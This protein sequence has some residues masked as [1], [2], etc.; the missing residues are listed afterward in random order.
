MKKKKGEK[1]ERDHFLS[2]AV[3]VVE[4]VAV[5]TAVAVAVSVS[6]VLAVASSALGSASLEEAGRGEERFFP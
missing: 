6:P 3:S 1:K 4:A 5:G 2:L